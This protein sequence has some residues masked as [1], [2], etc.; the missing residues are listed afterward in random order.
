MNAVRQGYMN[1]QRLDYEDC[2]QCHFRL[3]R[4]S[5]AGSLLSHISEGRHTHGEP[6]V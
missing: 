5:A 6:A 4:V 1:L 3:T 2:I